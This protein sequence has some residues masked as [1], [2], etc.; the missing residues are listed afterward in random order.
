MKVNKGVM[1]F[2]AEH[3]P[4]L[5]FLNVGELYMAEQVFGTRHGRCNGAELPRTLCHFFM[6]V[7]F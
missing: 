2:L 6:L 4:R 1:D 7:C 5:D 3:D